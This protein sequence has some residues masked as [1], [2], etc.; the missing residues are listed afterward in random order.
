MKLDEAKRLAEEFPG[1]TRKEMK[2]LA[3]WVAAVAPL[4]VDLA[5]CHESM[6]RDDY[7]KHDAIDALLAA[8]D[9]AP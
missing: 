6:E 5:R 8:A 7:R 9:G 1:V 4:I 3:V 2:A